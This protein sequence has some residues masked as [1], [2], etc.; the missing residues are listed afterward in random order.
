MKADDN[1]TGG[2]EEKRLEKRVR[3]Q[4]KHRRLVGSEAHRHDHVAELRNRGVGEDSF[5]I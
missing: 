4:V 1:R 5:D 2:E 3:E